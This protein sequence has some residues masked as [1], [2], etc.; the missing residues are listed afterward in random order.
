MPKRT[1]IARAV[2]RLLLGAAMIAETTL[3]EAFTA[4]IRSGWKTSEML[5]AGGRIHSFGSGY[6]VQGEQMRTLGLNV[7]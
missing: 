4:S 5:Y 6:G 1:A 3:L 7:F 2:M